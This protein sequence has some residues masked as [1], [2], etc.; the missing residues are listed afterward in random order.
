MNTINHGLFDNLNKEFL[1]SEENNI[2]LLFEKIKY[3]QGENVIG[4]SPKIQTKNFFYEEELVKF[5][6]NEEGLDSLSTLKEVAQLFQGVIRPH[7]P[8]AL[9]NMLPSPLLDTIAASTM[10]QLYNVNSL[11]DNFGGKSLIF[12]QKVARS[13]GRLIGWPQSVGISCNGGKLTLLYA[14]RMALSRMF[15]DSNTKGIPTNCVI[16]T[17]EPSHYCVEHVC[18]LLGLGSES[19]IRVAADENW[20]MCERALT[21]TIKEQVARGKK[22]AAVICCGGTTINFAHD[23][24]EKIY[25]IVM[26]VLDKLNQNYKPHFHLDSVIGW[27][28]F[29]FKRDSRIHDMDPIIKGK[30]QQII[31]RQKGLLFF[32]SCG[33]DFHKTGLCPY[34]TSFFI[35]SSKDMFNLLNDGSYVYEEEDFLYGN[36]RAY[37]YTV[38]NSRPASGIASAYVALRRL[39]IDGMQRYFV[40]LHRMSLDIAK[41]LEKK[42]A[43]KVLN[44]DS[45][46]WEIIFSI[47]F[48][49]LKRKEQFSTLNIEQNFITFCWNKCENG[50]NFPFISFVPGYKASPFSDS[51]M[52]FLIYPMNLNGRE[53]I[54]EIIDHLEKAVHDFEKSVLEG[55]LILNVIEKEKTIK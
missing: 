47:R 13:L 22:I 42:V 45:L 53:C 1:N 30:I 6:L 46:G 29:S 20:Q 3:I 25:H 5:S 35:A 14:I 34:S 38:E 21:E 27:L 15:P 55:T 19:C 41:E 4:K 36:F 11:M 8:F 18:M 52:A 9:F 54:E 33:V 10:T 28:V 49:K 24:T 51:Q 2:S 23:D 32:D 37:R 17:N 16:L 39:G 7:S 31:H 40:A 43:F 26:Q 44:K 12:E 50:D 48:E